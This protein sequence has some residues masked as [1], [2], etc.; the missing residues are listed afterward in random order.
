M[1]D[2]VKEV[3]VRKVVVSEF[4]TLDG[5]IEDPGGAEGFEHGGWSFRFDR[6]DDGDRLKF[7]ELAAADALLLGR[8]TYEGFAA[9]WPRMEEQT[10]EYGAW[11][12]GYPKHVASR[13]LEEP[14]EWNNST[15]IEGDVAEGV[16]KLKQQDGKDILVFGSAELARTLME[17][18]LVDEYRLMVFPIVV[19]KGKR[20]FG[21]TEETK[22]MKLVD[23]KRVGPDGVLIH[24]NRPA[25]EEA[26]GRTQ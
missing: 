5:V 14:L 17:H 12:N 20:L 13:T 10:G 19:G 21:E 23:T 2:E 1:R 7:D 8:V 24:T 15:L 3:P 18:D 25:G 26:G 11:M 22:A 4:V 6:G 16:S 9:A